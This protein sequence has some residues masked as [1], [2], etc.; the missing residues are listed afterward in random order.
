MHEYSEGD[1]YYVLDAF[2]TKGL[3][4]NV[5]YQ[6]TSRGLKELLAKNLRDGSRIPKALFNK[7]VRNNDLYTGG[8]GTTGKDD[9]VPAQKAVPHI[10]EFCFKKTGLAWNE[11]HQQ[12][13]FNETGTRPRI[14]DKQTRKELSEEL[15]DLREKHYATMQA[16]EPAK[17][18]PLEQKI[19]DFLR[20]RV[21]TGVYDHKTCIVI[22]C[23]DKR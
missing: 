12:A 18:P 9:L 3:R 19:R 22:L 13:L 16:G 21:I 5:T 11:K 4:H 1:G 6:I 10:A 23:H 8:T 15:D 14:A 20:G 2:T 7:L 17:I